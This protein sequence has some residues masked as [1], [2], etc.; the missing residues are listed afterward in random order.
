MHKL[1]GEEKLDKEFTICSTFWKQ[2]RLTALHGSFN[3]IIW[4]FVKQLDFISDGHFWIKNW[5][6]DFFLI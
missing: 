2:Q 6:E 1:Q 3:G 4:G 5:I